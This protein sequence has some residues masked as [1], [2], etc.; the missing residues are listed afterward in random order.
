MRTLRLRAWSRSDADI[1]SV[2]FD[3]DQCYHDYLRDHPRKLSYDLPF[4]V[5][6]ARPA[7][8]PLPWPVPL[9]PGPRPEWGVPAVIGAAQP[10]MPVASPPADFWSATDVHT[11]PP[12]IG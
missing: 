1:R 12:L 7:D 6:M 11:T 2:F 5:A 4:E 3:L 9:E 10:P 8:G